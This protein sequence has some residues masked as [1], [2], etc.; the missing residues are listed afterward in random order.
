MMRRSLPIKISEY[1]KTHA[2]RKRWKTVVTVL[3]CIVVFCTTYALI[4][5]AITMSQTAYCGREEHTHGESCY[6]KVLVCTGETDAAHV[7][8]D[9]C[10]MEQ[11][12]L[13]CGKTEGEGAHMH[14]PACY[15][16]A[17]ELVCGTEESAGHV[18]TEDCYTVTRSLICEQP[19]TAA[20]EHTESCYEARLTCDIEEHTHTAA[21]YADT[22]ADRETAEL[23]EKAIPQELSGQWAEDVVA[24]A[25]SQ[26]GYAESKQNYI[27]SDETGALYGY[28]RYGEW[29]GDPYG[30]WCAM[31]ASF[32]LR[33]AGIPEEDFPVDA[34]CIHWTEALREA[35]LFLDAGDGLPEAGDLIFFDF[36]P[37]NDIDTADHVG[38]VTE[39]SYSETDGTQIKTIEGNISDG[40]HDSVVEMTYAADDPRI[41]G[42][43][44]LPEQPEPDGE[45]EPPLLCGMEEHTHGE[46]CCDETGE[47]VCA[48]PEHTHTAECRTPSAPEEPAESETVR[49][50]TYE[51]E[52]IFVVLNVESPEALPEGTELF[53]QTPAEDSESSRA[54]RNYAQQSGTGDSD[55]LILKQFSLVQG[56]QVLDSADCTMTAEVTVKEGVLAPLAAEMTE[57]EQTLMTSDPALAAEVDLGISVAVLETD[58][59]H[60]VSEMG[61]MSLT[62]DETAAAPALS[63]EL[64]N[65]TLALFA[66]A[67]NPSYTV[68]YYAEIPRFAN[69][70][71]KSIDVFET[72]A[73]H[74]GSLP[75]NGTSATTTTVYLNNAGRGN[76][77]GNNGNKSTT[78]YTIATVNALTEIY[79]SEAFE[80][81]NAPNTMYMNKLQ[82]NPNYELSE[83]WVLK[84]GKDAAS[85][86]RDDWEIYTNPSSVHFTNRPAVS[87]SDR[88]LIREG[89]CIR[90]V[91]KT[92][93]ENG[94]SL[95]AQYYDYDI[96]SGYNGSAWVTGNAS[97]GVGINSKSNY[98][99]VSGNNQRT[100]DSTSD[101]YA[102]GN[103][104]CGTGMASQ[105]HDSIYMNKHS[106]VTENKGCNFNIVTGV[107]DDFTYPIYHEW[108]VAPHLFG[109]GNS[110]GKHEY[111]GSLGFERVGDTFRLTTAN[112]SGVGSLSGLDGFNHPSPKADTTYDLILTNNFWPMDNVPAANR[113]DPLFGQSGTSIYWSGYAFNAANTDDRQTKLITGTLPA[114]D[115]GN[116]HNSFFGMRTSLK[117]TLTEDYVGPL[118]YFFYGD[119]DLWVFLDHTLVC[120]VGGVHSS[121]GEIVDLWDYLTPLTPDKRFGDHTLSIFYTERGASGSSCYMQFTLP[122]VSGYTPQQVTDSLRVEKQV[123][124]DDDTDFNVDFSF[125][126]R[127]H[128]GNGSPVLDDYAY[129]KYN[130]DGSATEER[131]LIVCDGDTFTLRHGQYIIIQNL[132]FGLHYTVTETTANGYAVTTAVNGTAGSGTEANGQITKDQQNLVRFTNKRSSEDFVGA[133]V[134]KAGQD[135]AL[136]SGAAFTLKDA[137]G[138]TLQFIRQTDGTYAA[139][140]SAGSS[141]RSGRQYYVVPYGSDLGFA[142]AGTDTALLQKNTGADGQK[143]TLTRQSDGFYTFTNASGSFLH[144][145]N[146]SLA[147]GTPVGMVSLTG[148]AADAEKWYPEPVGDGTYRIRPKAAYAIYGEAGAFSLA[149]QGETSADGMAVDLRGDADSNTQKWL[150]I[151]VPEDGGA[152][153]ITASAVTGENG[154]LRFTGLKPGD[155]TLTEIQAPEGCK[156]PGAPNDSVSFRISE[157][158]AASLTGDENTLVTLENG[159]LRVTNLYLPKTV[160]IRKE[161]Q[162]LDAPTADYTF[163]VAWT[164]DGVET[165]QAISVKAGGSSDKISIPYAA[166]VTI[167]ETTAPGDTHFSVAYYQNEQKIGEGESVT[168]ES[169]TGDVTIRCVNT[170][171]QQLTIRKEVDTAAGAYPA[172]REFTFEVSYSDASG[173][174]TQTVTVKNGESQTISIPRGA[175]V[176]LRETESGGLQ[177]LGYRAES[178]TSL[179][180][181]DENGVYTLSANATTRDLVFT[182][183]NAP[184]LT[185]E[186]EVVADD[187]AAQQKEYEIKLSYKN[188]A[189]TLVTKYVKL[190]PG[191]PAEL[192]IPYG[193]TVTLCETESSRAGFHVQYML[194]GEELSIDPQTHAC[195]FEMTGNVTV[196]TVNT[197]GYELPST[198]GPGTALY[199]AAGLLLIFSALCTDILQ[200]KRRDER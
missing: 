80:Y 178:G 115:D 166:K 87:G 86:N 168:I 19:E 24:I 68:Q 3:S 58:E 134:Q 33:Y 20:H 70:G 121:V 101:V 78:I 175:E 52:E 28:T 120:D 122:N 187:A 144:L 11:R 48:L 125:K 1:I 196:K 136:L 96:S 8:G 129:T 176:K 40:V 131:D 195:T 142:L 124:S 161:V 26:L 148:D 73:S 31:F 30:D 51:D 38:I 169:L 200:R 102:F 199:I 146:N 16:E 63:V 89:T 167:T 7:H 25:E 35:G 90:L 84:D 173:D 75:K 21:C 162:N 150:L 22:T 6:E 32:C 10:Y 111:G 183:V 192:D 60:A 39:V 189:N 69:S 194:D 37:D 171:E 159:V 151:P 160:T 57:L 164:V 117:F 132:P 12:T 43:G 193:A 190:T 152:P 9:E 103:A 163:D 15:D 2:R 143:F 79:S 14:A 91:Y 108:V 110:T 155:Y 49:Q 67:A 147:A 198:G 137:D 94:R 44:L 128:D 85:T 114:S 34:N 42:F 123:E 182:A 197:A 118:E 13:T 97:S 112:V 179:L 47:L 77:T 81:I 188:S 141:L 92:T 153:D 29:Y 46:A 165:K 59:T 154:L 99:A 27:V 74:N 107:S 65:G 82:E 100:W 72:R 172:D 126:I 130:A 62:A 61:G 41:L 95:S 174:H 66:S 116:N 184:R 109:D 98:P 105:K 181:P 55:R 54:I 135:G 186:K 5:P 180:K 104:N 93:T 88:I 23:W 17:G 18:H 139:V 64:Q 127:F 177:L 106:G 45:E 119:D 56:G 53:A 50:F 71:E 4:L 170:A 140:T 158:G 145:Q 149:R 185:L 138:N 191:T 76:Y 83:L 113:T 133:A 156:L 36:D 157:D